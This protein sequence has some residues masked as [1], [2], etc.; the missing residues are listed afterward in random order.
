MIRLATT[1]DALGALTAEAGI[2]GLESNLARE[3]VDAAVQAGRCLV[4]IASTDAVDGF[5]VTSVRSFFGRD[6]V[7]LLA[8]S[9]S[10][11]RSGIGSALLTAAA[12][13][14]T[15]DVVF[16]STNESNGAMRALLRRDNWTYSGTLTG[17]DEGDPE[18][19]FWRERIILPG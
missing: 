18:L 9:A 10:H 3:L 6:F 8:V 19:V 12:L 4:H 15:T 5:V 11:R 17:L 16:T 13:Q 14:A 1:G 7:R 2:P